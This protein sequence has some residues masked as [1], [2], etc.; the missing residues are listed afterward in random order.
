MNPL[1]RV[2]HISKSFPGVRA[3]DDVSFDV[4]SG[5]V[6]AL[7]GENGAGKSTLVQVL[8][9]VLRPDAGT[10]VLDGRPV[11]FA[12]P[13][14]AIVAGISMVF[15][16]LSL[17][18]SLSIAENIFA[19]RQPVN[20]AGL[21][22]W[23]SLHSA[24]TRLLRDFGLELDP[25]TPVKRLS[26]GQQQMVEILKAVSTQPKLLILDEPTSSLTEAETRQLFTV[27]GRLREQGIGLIY[28]SH[29]LSEV[30]TV[31]DRIVVLRDGRFVGSRR[32][33]DVDEDDLVSMMV[34]RS[35]GNLY[36]TPSGAVGEEFFRVEGFTRRPVLD[37]V[38]FALRRG[39]ILGLAGLVGAG[40]TELARTIVGLERKSAGEVW[41]DGLP[42]TIGSPRDAIRHRIAYLTEDRKALGLFLGLS[43]RENVAAVALRD[44]TS[45]LGFLDKRRIAAA[46]AGAIREYGIATPST[47]KKLLYL[48]GGNQQKTMIAAWMQVAPQVII[49]D[50]PTRGVDVGAK[51]EIY[52]KLRELAGTGVGIVLIS[53][54]LPE[55]IGMCDRVLVM[56]SGRISGEVTRA[57]FSEER[58]LAYAAGIA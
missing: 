9:G 39:E 43:V 27:I 36:G 45:R 22:H 49:F 26:P 33:A 44:F 42:A 28:I 54:E 15:Q 47:E 23:P 48:S 38:S 2:E 31:A 20:A 5:E 12:S 34:G 24:A 30:F 6:L 18:G 52:Q 10:V 53:S 17:V 40:R 7:I 56:C 1:L 16:E 32:P 13:H 46:T 4:H 35:I 58:I 11:S 55:L 50:E 19:N 37:D 41:L 21:V 29:K 3:V 25:R 51:A 14:D 57:E 8:G